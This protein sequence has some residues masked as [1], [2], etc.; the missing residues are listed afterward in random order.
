MRIIELQLTDFRCFYGSQSI[1]F[2]ADHEKNITLIHGENGSGKSTVLNAILWCFYGK[3]AESFKD[4]KDLIN[5][6]ALSEGNPNYSV[7]ITF[8]EN[9]ANYLV[10][11][12]G[13]NLKEDKF[14]VYSISDDGNYKEVR[15]PQYFINSIIPKDMA[16]YFF[17]SGES[18]ASSPGSIRKAVRDI[19]G[20]T[21]A[22]LAIES[23]KTVRSALRK[24]YADASPSSTAAERQKQLANLETILGSDRKKLTALREEEKFLIERKG[25]IE[26]KL[27]DSDHRVVQEKQKIRVQ[28]ENEISNSRI[29]LSRFKN[30]KVSL[31]TNY[32]ISSFAGRAAAEGISFIDDSQLKGTIPAPYNTQLVH[33]ILEETRCICGAE[34]SPG[35]EAFANIQ[36]LLAKAADPNLIGRISRARSQLTGIKKDLGRV[37]EETRLVLQG[38]AQTE[39]NID[40]A[41]SQLEEISA[42]IQGIDIDSIKNDEKERRELENQ[43]RENQKTQARKNHDIESAVKTIND[44]EREL[45]RNKT[46][47]KT[48]VE[49]QD[50]VVYCET[51][52]ATLTEKLSKAEEDSVGL[53]TKIINDF[54]NK[55]V[56]KDYYVAI[57]RDFELTL[58]DGKD[59]ALVKGWNT[60]LQLLVNLVFISSLIKIAKIR[61]GAQGAILTPGAIAPFVIDA[62]FG[63]LDKSYQGSVAKQIPDAA[64]QVVLLLSST[65]W[66]SS[67]DDAI[68][69]K[70]GAEYTLIEEQS[71]D[72][73]DKPLENISIRGKVFPKVKYG[74]PTDCTTIE[75]VA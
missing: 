57:S 21:V 28:K 65:H 42:Q 29:A 45:E 1:A 2:A 13:E 10:Q 69:E 55:A 60:G 19:L 66:S 51:L 50:R 26:K 73:K 56:R 35:T 22:E 75:R 61:A 12:H 20:F 46:K 58:L 17:F 64:G 9:G 4:S 47:E 44:L 67:V 63:V 39:S 14:R 32:A 70:V 18:R 62:P 37:S 25:G 49:L 38:I 8:E 3:T 68:K 16:E 33:D 30:Q 34:I 72:Q 11:R 40:T 48:A 41:A 5:K 43:I 53:I 27:Q 6:A 31:V 71:G 36:K 54:L 74:R 24:R 52:L 59:K 7:K 15:S 23:I